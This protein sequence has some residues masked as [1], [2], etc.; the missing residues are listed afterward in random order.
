MKLEIFNSNDM[1]QNVY[2]YYDGATGEGV[3]VDAGCSAADMQR[4]DKFLNEHGIKVQAI[5]LTHGHYDHI[6]SAAE[7]K[8]ITGAEAYCHANEQE[9]MESAELNRS[10]FHD[11]EITFSPDKLLADGDEIGGLRVIHTPGHTPGGVCYYDAE[12]GVLFSGDTLFHENI[13]RTDFPYADY[14]ELLQNIR[15]K[16]FVLPKDTKVFPGH[17]RDTTIGHEQAA[18]AA[19]KDWD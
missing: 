4:L 7:A 15:E 10:A 9:I 18:W 11:M 13:G 16:L 12:N 17:G 1:R 3:L 19:Y 14:N 5:L 6:I 8:K 2:L